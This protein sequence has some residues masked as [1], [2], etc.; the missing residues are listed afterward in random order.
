MGGL[1]GAVA[2][3]VSEKCPT[4]VLRVGVKDKF[5]KSGNATELL[6]EYGLTYENI[7]V[8][9]KEILR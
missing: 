1:G 5:G 9:V 2:E 4:K 8:R 3:V 7:I 6:E